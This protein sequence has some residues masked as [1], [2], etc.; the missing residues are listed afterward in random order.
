MLTLRRT[1]DLNLVRR[2]L[3]DA[4]IYSRMA[5][6]Y[7]PPSTDYQPLEHPEMIYVAVDLNGTTQ[8]IFALIPHSRIMLEVHTCLLPDCWGYPA[9]EAAQKLIAWVWKNTPCQR[10]I[11]SVPAFNRLAFMFAVA[12]GMTEYGC[13]PKAFMKNQRLHDIIMLGLSRPEALRQS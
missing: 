13:N 10:L 4:R 3:T 8:G 11:T 1:A 7:A 12:A 9:A 6:D 5:D 2:V